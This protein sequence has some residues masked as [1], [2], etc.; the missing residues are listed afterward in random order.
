M[1]AR[2]REQLEKLLKPPQNDCCLMCYEQDNDNVEY[3]GKIIS[4]EEFENLSDHGPIAFV[5]HWGKSP[6]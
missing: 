4:M 6:F 5:V 1:K 2:K 3:K